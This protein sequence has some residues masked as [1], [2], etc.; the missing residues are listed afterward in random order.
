MLGDQPTGWTGRK[1]KSYQLLDF[2]NLISPGAELEN[3]QE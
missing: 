2:Q 1:P 3:D